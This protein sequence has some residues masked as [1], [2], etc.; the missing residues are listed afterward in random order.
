MV[1]KNVPGAFSSNKGRD[2]QRILTECVR[3]AEPSAP[4]VPYPDKDKWTK[5]GVLM[6][7]GFSIAYRVLDAQYWG[8]PQ[9]RRRIALV[10]DFGGQS[11][12][13]ILFV[14]ESL[15]GN[16]EAG[17][18]AGETFT[19]GIGDDAYPSIA[20]SLTAR[21][22]GSP[23]IDRGPNTEGV[24]IVPCVYDAQGNGDGQN[25]CTLTGDNANRVT[26]YTPIVAR[27]LTA[28]CYKQKGRADAETYLSTGGIVRRLTP[29]E[30]ER[31]QGFPDGWTDIGEWEDSTGK[32]HK[33]SDSARYRALGN[34]IALPPWK[35][36][37]KRIAAQYERDATLGSLFDGI[38]GF[39]LIWEQINGKGSAVWCSEIEPFCIAVAKWH[40]PDANNGE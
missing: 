7:D 39:P 6:G 22:D 36:V 26:D 11:A 34:S 20:R 10:C 31:L 23:C 17:G 15:S 27:C 9:R 18:T 28:N 33:T 21:Y 16:I 24:N 5:A 2:F 13:E 14:R 12:P 3:I 8:V 1:W 38:S 25:V 29:L 37:L 32:R 19:P 30:A 4:D 40:F 35:W